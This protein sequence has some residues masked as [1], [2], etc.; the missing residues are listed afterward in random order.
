MTTTITGVTSYKGIMLQQHENIFKV[1]GDFLKEIKPK[2]ILEIG[3]GTGA[4]TLFIRDFLD[5]NGLSETEIRTFDVNDNT[6]VHDRLRNMTNVIV[7]K[8]N[9]F[10]GGN[11]F[12]LLRYDLIESY[13]KLEGTTLVLCDGGCK[14]KEFNQIAPLIKVGDFIMAHDYA[15]TREN[16]DNKIYD[17]IWNWREIGDE[18][19]EEA[20]QKNNLVPYNKE[21]FDS[22]V[23]VCRKK[24]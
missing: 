23:W 5:E 21:N 4:L 2:R 19:I 1:L 10:A 20:V 12:T 7:S 8:E 6:E 24:Q 22:V 15:D 18:D 16:F 9:L 11:D 3:T 14:I 17:K 13:I